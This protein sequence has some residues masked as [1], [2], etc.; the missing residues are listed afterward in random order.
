MHI[1]R[2]KKKK[3]KGDVGLCMVPMVT[4]S[5]AKVL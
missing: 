3:K 2:D 5:R 4:T 1:A